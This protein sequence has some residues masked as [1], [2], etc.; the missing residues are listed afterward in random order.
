MAIKWYCFV[1]SGVGSISD[2]TNTKCRIIKGKVAF[3]ACVGRSC[4]GDGSDT[5]SCRCNWI[6]SY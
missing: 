3:R 6:G 1:L 2:S 5:I 4:A